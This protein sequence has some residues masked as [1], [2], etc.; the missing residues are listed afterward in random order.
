VKDIL[1]QKIKEK[2][3]ECA[4]LEEKI[5]TL[6]KNLEK[7]QTKLNMNLQHIKGPEKLDVILNAQRSPL[8]KVGLGYEGESSESKIEEKKTTTFVKVVKGDNS[9]PRQ[10][11]NN[12]LSST[13]N[14]Q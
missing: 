14:Q 12:N 13:S 8:M 11:E 5:V 3:R 6:K 4:R 1:L 9:S 2:S 10:F 7:A